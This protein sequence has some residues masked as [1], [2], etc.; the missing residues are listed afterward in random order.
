MILWVF[1]EFFGVKIVITDI[2]RYFFKNFRTSTHAPQS[3]FFSGK[4]GIFR[5]FG[6]KSVILPIFPL[7]FLLGA[8]R[9]PIFR[10]SIGRKKRFF[11]P[12][13]QYMIDDIFL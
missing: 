6:K 12:C 11:V 5:F 8:D 10:R 2:Y 3:R 1:I 9:K 4:I 13:I 7:L